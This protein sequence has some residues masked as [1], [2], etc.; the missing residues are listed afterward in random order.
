MK[1][2]LVLT[3]AFKKDV[4]LMEKRNLNLQELNTVVDLLLNDTPLPEKYCDHRLKGNKRKF[5]ELHINPDWLLLYIKDKN[6]LILTLTR[7]G[8]HSDLLDK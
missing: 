3:A 1:Y 4:R 6:M 5:R 8:T 7:T 2:K